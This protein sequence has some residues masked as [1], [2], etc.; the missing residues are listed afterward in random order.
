MGR[1]ARRV[2]IS[3]WAMA[4]ACLLAAVGT[5]GAGAQE[6][7]ARPVELPPLPD[8]LPPL[9][10]E[11]PP[12]P[13]APVATGD[14]AA[15]DDLFDPGYDAGQESPA[16]STTPPP[17]P[18]PYA[19]GPRISRFLLGDAF[20]LHPTEL[21]PGVSVF[22]SNTQFGQG[23]ASGG[24]DR[25]GRWGSKFDMLAHVDSAGLGLWRG[26]AID[27]FAESRLGQSVEPL[28]RSYSPSNLAM[29]F[30]VPNA[31][32]TAI[33]GLK[34]TQA[35]GD[36]AGVFLGKL[37]ALNGDREK[38]LN[39]PLTSRFW[40]AAFNFNLALDRYPYSAPGAGFYYAMGLGPVLS[41]MVLDSHSSPRT[42]GFENLGSNGVFVYAEAKVPTRL[43]GL[44]GRQ[45]LGALY[46]N[47]KFADLDPT[48]FL[49][50]PAGVAS[51]R[52]TGTWT[53]LWHAEQRLYVD[54]DNP[55]RGLGIYRQIGLSDGNPNPIRWF[56]SVALVGN[57]PLLNRPGDTWGVGYYQIQL[58]SAAKSLAPGLRNEPGFEFFYNARIRPGV[59][60]T[61]DLQWVRPGL[62]P[63]PS[64][65]V[66][67][68]R[69]KVDF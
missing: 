44:P 67:G 12:L 69:L 5:P 34:F 1:D 47:G 25:Q 43:F 10:V 24:F 3:G 32:L 46:G 27:L 55:A 57:S 22:V 17:V 45:V 63:Y 64:A 53:L 11:L 56:F 30:P 26:G 51:P 9:P 42:S 19:N 39:Y 13:D 28:V 65:L 50:L 6:P 8:E 68:L 62:G 35:L 38:F 15:F 49:D 36:N 37:N 18:D 20:G 48:S 66:L 16:G 54:P 29:H 7:A 52:Q 31:Q 23:V 41:V 61:P 58:G 2:V 14:R 4:F 21:T 33:T 40:N 60:L 59:H